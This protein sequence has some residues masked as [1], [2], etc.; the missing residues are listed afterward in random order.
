MC[1]LSGRFCAHDEK[2]IFFWKKGNGDKMNCRKLSRYHEAQTAQNRNPFS[3]GASRHWNEMSDPIQIGYL[4]GFID[5]IRLG[6]LHAVVECIVEAHGAA[7]PTSGLSKVTEIVAQF[8][9][10]GIPLDQ[11]REGVT[12][13]CKRPE[14]SSIELSDALTAFIMKVEGKPQSDL[15]DYLTFARQGVIVQRS[16]FR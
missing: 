12:T 14:N 3:D 5:G 7:E 11:V 15:E 9:A 1:R 6:A 4:E 8:T 16:R 13:I 2:G 10:P